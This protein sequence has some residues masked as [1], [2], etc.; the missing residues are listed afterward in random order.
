MTRTM[1]VAGNWKMNL[2]EEQAVA[3]AT[4]LANCISTPATIEVALVPPFPWLVPVR[5]A[6]GSSAILLGAQNCHQAP[7]GAFTGEVSASMLTPLC[8]FI[9]A[10]HSE[11][12]HLFH[13]SD[14]LVGMKVDAILAAGSR[15]VLCVGETLA[16]RD[17]G[18]AQTVVTRQLA[19]GLTRVDERSL[20][21]VVV[22]YEPVWAI[23]TGIAATAADAQDMCASIRG[24]LAE[25]FGGAGAAISVLYGGSVTPDNAA[26]LFGQPDID[27]GLVGGA[28]LKSDSF[29]LI[30]SAAAAIVGSQL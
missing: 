17:A 14:E 20:P 10:G 30:V 25:R 28:S 27:G 19:A 24:W 18:A 4:S 1:L 7:G 15:A 8:D 21:R 16:D 13:E 11:R 3:L 26:E 23:G 9:L 22:A 29:Q 6:L 12:R 2:D 5:V